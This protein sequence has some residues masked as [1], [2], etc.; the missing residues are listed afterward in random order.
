MT[1]NSKPRIASQI[2]K[3]PTSWLILIVF[4]GILYSLFQPWANSR[5]GLKLPS[6]P[7]MMSSEKAQPTQIPQT[8]QPLQPKQVPQQQSQQETEAQ[9]DKNETSQNA[10]YDL[11]KNV[12]SEVYLSE[13]GL[14]YTRGSE[15]GHRLKHLARHLEDIPDRN[16]NHGVFEGGWQVT[17]QRIDE[18]YRRSQQKDPKTKIRQEDKRSVIETE[19]AETIGYVG[20][21]DGA[22]KGNPST[23][24]LRLVTEGDRFITA[25]PY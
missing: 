11:L 12:G 15:E 6:I 20:G 16:G 17:L 10:P 13:A 22:R 24:R 5:L 19:F 7:Q 18:A 4:L 9:P 21:K 14:R 3:L 1:T 2:A 23:R 8:K 25:F